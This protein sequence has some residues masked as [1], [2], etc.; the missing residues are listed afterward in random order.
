MMAGAVIIISAL[1][2][3]KWL[4]QKNINRSYRIVELTLSIAMAAYLLLNGFQVPAAI[5]G[6][7]AVVLG[8]SFSLEGSNNETEGYKTYAYY[9]KA[10]YKNESNE[11][12]AKPYAAIYN[13]YM[14]DKQI[15]VA[16]TVGTKAERDELLA[17]FKADGYSYQRATRKKVSAENTAQEY[18]SPNHPGIVL[19]MT[20]YAL[21]EG[22]Q[23]YTMY[24][25]E[26]MKPLK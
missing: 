22:K 12:V 25:F 5:F 21:K 3:N 19:F 17:Q 10:I 18:T 16:H 1:F 2:R 4:L 11:N 8:M 6:I 13:L 20:T 15:G 26:L 23:D 24:E 9:T 7:L 14:E